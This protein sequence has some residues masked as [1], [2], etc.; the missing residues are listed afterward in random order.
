MR[1]PGEFLGSGDALQEMV[2]SDWREMMPNGNLDLLWWLKI[3]RNDK[4]IHTQ[5][6]LFVSLLKFKRHTWLFIAKIIKSHCVID[7]ISRCNTY[8]NYSIK[9]WGRG[10]HIPY[11][12]WT[13]TTLTLN[14]LWKL[15][16][17]IVISRANTK[18][19]K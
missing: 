17:Y 16:M 4:Y 9:W 14:K 13:G 3:T 2:P 6:R 15:W 11:F 19:K 12:T 10:L 7:G 1:E 8:D 18:N 5:K